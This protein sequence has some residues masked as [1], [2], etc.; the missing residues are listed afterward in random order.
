MLQRALK[1][2]AVI[3]R[4][5]AEGRQA[6]ILRKG[7]IEEPAGTFHLEHRRFW[8]Y[9]TYVHQ[10]RAGIKVEAAPLLEQAEAERPPAGVVRLTHF[11]EVAGIYQV[12]NLAGALAVERLHLWSE[13][14]V[15]SRFAYRRPG[16]NV[17]TARVYRAAQ[18][19]DLAEDP[20]YAGCRSWVELGRALPTEGAAPALSGEA[21]REVV[22]ELESLLNPTAFA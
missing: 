17:L 3:C 8:L 11:A 15:R 9:P 13:E 2:W 21:F 4:A 14:T 18:P 1:E 6:M 7:G 12:H 16:L 22:I 10:Q 19:V 20:A 5:L